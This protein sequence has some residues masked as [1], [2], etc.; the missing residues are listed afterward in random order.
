MDT[1]Y[2]S[3][4]T[5]SLLEQE[6]EQMFSSPSPSSMHP[7]QASREA[8][9]LRLDASSMDAEAVVPPPVGSGDESSLL[10]VV[11]LVCN[12]EFASK[13]S[14]AAHR[15]VHEKDGE[16]T[17]KAFHCSFCSRTF[18]RSANLKKH[19]QVSHADQLTPEST[20]TMEL[21]QSVIH[22]Q[23]NDAETFAHFTF[24]KTPLPTE[25]HHDHT[26]LFEVDPTT[27]RNM[28]DELVRL[29]AQNELLTSQMAQLFN[30]L[31]RK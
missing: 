22:E 18:A 14:L 7:S 28:H 24:D 19:V 2:D 12:R 31:A 16:A 23:Q 15:R 17:E 27:E 21:E 11:C 30:L 1:T 9:P 8:S 13:R 3:N 5:T 6:L 4:T 29:R 25:E 26:P 20:T 10:P